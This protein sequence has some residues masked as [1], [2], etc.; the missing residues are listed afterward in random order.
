M[1][2]R[3]NQQSLALR[4]RFLSHRQ[5]IDLSSNDYLGFSQDPIL[6]ERILGSL[7]KYKDKYKSFP[8][9]AAGS[10]LLRGNLEIHEEAERQLAKFCSRE[11]SLIFPSGYQ[12]NL[13]L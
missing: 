8:I 2:D 6:A 13:G 3:L 7:S 12:A 10:R 9:G 4:R 1:Q 11:A 5:G